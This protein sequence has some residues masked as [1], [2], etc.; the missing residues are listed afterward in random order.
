[1]S[2]K[3]K[4]VVTIAPLLFMPAHSNLS[5]VLGQFLLSPRSLR[6]EQVV[7]TQAFSGAQIW[8]VITDQARFCL[9]R[10][11]EGSDF[12]RLSSIHRVL[13]H[14]AQ[15]GEHCIATPLPACDGRTLLFHDQAY[16]EL[17][18]WLPGEVEAK[19][20]VS[21]IKIENA[22][23]AMAKIH[24]AAKSYSGDAQFPASQVGMPAG[25]K[26]RWIKLRWWL[27]TGCEHL[28]AA[29][30]DPKWNQLN[31]LRWFFLE[32]LKSIAPLLG[33][34]IEGATRSVVPLQ[35]CLRD[36]WR[37]NVLFYGDQVTGIIDYDALRIDSVATD[38]ARLLGSLAGDEPNLWHLGCVAYAE[39]RPLSEA[40]RRLVVCYDRT[41]VLLTGLQWL[42]W[43]LLE[44]REFAN[45]AAVLE[46]LAE[47]RLR[48]EQLS[49]RIT[50]DQ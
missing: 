14:I 8:R 46:R 38:V 18:P 42:E 12:A 45:P 20:P 34:E 44:Q 6:I 21:P 15:Q 31:D 22:M 36:V 40:E 9:R 39:I 10:W 16:W 2:V 24:L 23:R 5:T 1:M 49:R 43:I 50:V 35:I 25:L 32:R 28:L 37:A 27:E 13:A 17:A 33:L 3:L 4:K 7:S 48:L 19:S 41:A 11:P 47:T 26:N 29:K 30:I